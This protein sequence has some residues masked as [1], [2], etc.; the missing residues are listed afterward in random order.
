MTQRLLLPR[1]RTPNE[2]SEGSH[3][4][5]SPPSGRPA[6]DSAVNFIS[7][8]PLGK[9]NQSRA[10]SRAGLGSKWGGNL[11]P[12]VTSRDQFAHVLYIEIA[13]KT[14]AVVSCGRLYS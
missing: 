13:R 9:Q 11:C 6:T 1:T 4:K 10:L 8:P 12:R 2:G 7:A 5:W 3:S 14:S